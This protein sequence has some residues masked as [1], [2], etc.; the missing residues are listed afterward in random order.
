MLAEE[1]VQ[2]NQRTFTRLMVS[3]ASGMGKLNLLLAVC[4]R[5]TE[6]DGWVQRYEAELAVQ[7]KRCYRVKLDGEQPSLKQSLLDLQAT[8]VELGEGAVVTVMG[9]AELLDLRLNHEDRS[10]LERLFF[11]L[12]WTRESLRGF[13]CPIVIWITNRVADGMA[14]MAPDFWSWRGNSVFEFERSDD[15]EVLANV[16][17]GDDFSDAIQILKPKSFDQKTELGKKAAA[18]WQELE[19]LLEADPDSPLLARL[20]QNLGFTERDRG[21][22][23]SAET[24]LKK[25][26]QLHRIA[27][28]RS[29]EA[30]CLGCL[31]DIER[32][33]GNWDKAEQLYRQSL[34]LRKEL[35]DRSGMASSWGVLGDIERNRGNWDKAE[36]LYRQSLQL[37]EE[38]GDQ[39]GIAEITRDLGSNELGRGNLQM[40]SDL[41]LKALEQMQ[42]VG[43]TW[44]IA[45]THAEL[46]KLYRA[47]ANPQIAQQHYT[48]AHQLFSQLGAMKDLEKIEK[49]W[50]EVHSLQAIPSTN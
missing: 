33:R 8:G 9:A 22:W 30:F 40:A 1:Q 21:N 23:D 37:R 41:L 10:A 5:A 38:L 2:L 25:A 48:T 3:I 44:D 31:G 14:T 32:K 18:Q 35:G 45:E 24:V 13:E 16:P 20:Y 34:Q 50:N 7:G 49:E 6:R 4:D 36:Q 42:A 46:A 43:M 29:S 47:K 28:N 11:S 39:S 19:D 15:V 17:V 12:Q 26:I 27:N